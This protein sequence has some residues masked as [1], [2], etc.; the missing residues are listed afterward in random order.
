MF[1]GPNLAR[2]SSLNLKKGHR[3]FKQKLNLTR[4]GQEPNHDKS[5]NNLK[6]DGYK[7]VIVVFDFAL[8]G[9]EGFRGIIQKW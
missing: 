3:C 6:V 2:K 1:V 9:T 5:E 7:G 4:S 8:V